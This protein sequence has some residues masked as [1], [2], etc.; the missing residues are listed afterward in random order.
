M[1]SASFFDTSAL[2][3]RYYEEP[4]TEA[5]DS[6]IEGDATVVITSLSVIEAVSAFRRKQNT[7]DIPQTTVN[8]L[9]GAFF[10]EALAEFVILPLHE[11]LF[12]RSF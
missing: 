3:K 9:I 4:G 11:T 7:D 8:G 6:I 12:E 2:V 5:V 1:S 10:R